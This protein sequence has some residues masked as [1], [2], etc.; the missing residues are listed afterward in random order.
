MLGASKNKQPKVIGVA[1]TFGKSTVIQTISHVLRSSGF[2]VAHISSFSYCVDG[3][4]Q[5]NNVTANALTK[6]VFKE[7]INKARTK[8]VDFIIVEMTAKNFNQGVYNGVMLDVGII[9]NIFL[10]NKFYLNWEAYAETSLN[11][12][13]KIKPEGLLIANGEDQAKVL[14]L[15]EKS[16]DINHNIYTYWVNTS[17]LDNFASNKDSTNI[18][19]QETEYS[20]NLISDINVLNLYI[21]IR[22]CLEFTS[23]EN[24][25]KSLSNIPLS[26]GSL[27]I[28]STNPLVIIDSS[29]HTESMSKLLRYFEKIKEPNS[30]LISIIGF[31]DLLQNER[32]E[33]FGDILSK[34]DLSILSA[35]DPGFNPVSE[36]NSWI[37]NEGEKTGSRLVERISS[38]EELE[39]LN[40]DNMRR[41]IAGILSNSEKT[42]IA[43]DANDYT[44]RL[45]AINLAVKLSNPEDII[46][47][48]G[49]GISKTLNFG[50]VEYEWSD[51]E[52]YR[53]A[54][55]QT[56]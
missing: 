44:S 21:S 47:I 12:I 26:K 52:A 32:L 8:N 33:D 29:Y 41:R 14:W 22:T 7:F 4:H 13:R 35:L 3:V 31:H 50:D 34:S 25:V 10:P 15:L 36:I 24:I 18:W 1:G 55:N 30:K 38:T 20:S 28:L 53:I 56:N 27:E 6:P 51:E 42:M 49:K 17:S 2:L 54:L 11:I 19:Y 5:D 23:S 45:D 39:M 46:Y 40:K 43:M 48:P 37:I 9:T 16:S